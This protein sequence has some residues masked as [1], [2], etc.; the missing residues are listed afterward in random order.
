MM[1]HTLVII[2]AILLLAACKYDEIERDPDSLQCLGDFTYDQNVKF[3]IG[4][5]CSYSGCHDGSSAAPGNFLTYEGL[6]SRL[7]NGQ[8]ETRVFEFRDM[9]PGDATGPKI[10]TEPDLNTLRCWAEQ[11]FPQN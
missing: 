5:Y 11:G 3:L 9:P 2:S 1:K 10:I 7:N 4:T 8:F 6:E